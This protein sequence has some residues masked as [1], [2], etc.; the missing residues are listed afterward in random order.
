MNVK[1][2]V[3]KLES[4][5]YQKVWFDW[6][7]LNEHKTNFLVVVLYSRER[8]NNFKQKHLWNLANSVWR[9]L[10]CHRSISHWKLHRWVHTTSSK[11]PQRPRN[12]PIPNDFYSSNSDA[13]WDDF[14]DLS[15][16]A[17][18][19]RRPQDLTMICVCRRHQRC[20]PF[21]R[22]WTV[23]NDLGERMYKAGFGNTRRETGLEVTWALEINVAFSFSFFVA[24]RNSNIS[25][26]LQ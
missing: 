6:R 22:S 20:V 2:N 18:L 17:Q 13:D 14:P 12:R 9:A 4:T 1:Q 19:A 5:I 7:V 8:S 24:Q 10:Y 11:C 23:K 16:S 21:L 15:N 25:D 26:Y 3:K